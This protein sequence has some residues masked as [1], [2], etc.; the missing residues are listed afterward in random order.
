MA[1]K[2]TDVSWGLVA[3]ALHW[4]MAAIMISLLA[5]GFYM[6]E[7]EPDLVTRFKM[8]QI[9]KS[10]G[11]TV[12]VLGLIRIAW[13]ITADARPGLPPGMRPWERHAARISHLAFYALMIALPVTGWLM[14]SASPLND[15]DAFPFRVANMV[16]GVFELPDP[17]DPGSRQLTANLLTVHFSLALTLSALLLIHVAAALKHAF[18]NRDEVL[19]RMLRG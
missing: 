1:L 12:F 13:R 17:I 6:V 10:F 15:A 14:A 4:T 11:F 9:H 7:V 2:D 16:F 19:S 3:R 18:I 8:T 5:L